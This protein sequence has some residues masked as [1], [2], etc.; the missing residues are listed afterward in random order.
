MH[1]IVRLSEALRS[2]GIPASIRSTQNAYEIYQL[3]KGEDAYLK[4]ALSSVYVK[5]IRFKDKFNQVF[6]E[7]F[8][9]DFKKEDSKSQSQDSN[10]P[11]NTPQHNQISTGVDYNSKYKLEI[12]SI[13]NDNIDYNPSIEDYIDLGLN[14]DELSL[15]DR[16][17]NVL[18]FFDPELFDLCNKLGRKIANRRSRRFKRSKQMKPDIRKTL[19][20]NLKYGGAMLD[21]VK[22]KPHIKK[23]QHIFLSDVS[24]SCDWISNWFFCIVYAAQKSFYRSKFFD[25]DNKAVETTL[26]MQEKDL[27]N[28][29]ASVR[30]IRQKNI[31]IHGTSNMYRAFESFL[32]QASLNSRSSVIILS[33]CRDWAGPKKDKKPMSSLLIEKMVNKSKKVIILNPEDK[34][35]WNV[36]D[37]CVSDYQ[38][39]GALVKEVRNLRQL[40]ILIESL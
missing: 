3:L 14:M 24:G 9:D 11:K 4:D 2:K 28:A 21:I 35:K 26:A 20:K 12:K 31:M 29:F 25:F 40:S 38:D 19:R 6:D 17:I 30:D 13:K 34:K 15:M 18:D 32:K 16:D 10:K 1:K 33:D 39:A 8:R 23:N 37:S 7:L 5:D 27:L 36:V 22:S